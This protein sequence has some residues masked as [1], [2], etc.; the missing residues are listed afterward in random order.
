MSYN[1]EQAETPVALLRR[2]ARPP[3]VEERCDFCSVT[4]PPTHRHLLELANRKMICACDPCA[5]R[6][7]NVVGGRYKLVPREVRFLAGFII[8]EAQWD[9]FSLPIDLAFFYRDTNAGKFTAMYPSPAGAT[10][11]LLPSKNWERLEADNAALAEMQPDVEA[12][13]VNRLGG[14]R[15]YFVA[16]IDICYELAGLI[17]KH[18]RG[19]SGGETVWLELDRFFATLRERAEPSTVQATE[20]VHA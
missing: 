19:L 18:W 5:M 1:A 20:V 15:Q 6:F 8:T 13:L 14:A 2:L 7:Q 10:E 11:S 16:P 4:I 12:L 9:N 17:R 3:V